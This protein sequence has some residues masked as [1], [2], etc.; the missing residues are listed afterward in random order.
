MLCM[1]IS[2]HLQTHPQ[3]FRE[4]LLSGPLADEETEAHGVETT[5]H[6]T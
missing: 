3:F 2:F 5:A 6:T 4:M 1:A